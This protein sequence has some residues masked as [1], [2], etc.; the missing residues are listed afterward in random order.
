MSADE[1]SRIWVAALLAGDEQATKLLWD[2]YGEALQRVARRHVEP[3][4]RRRVEPEDIVQSACRSFFRHSA[5]GDY[6]LSDTESLWR[7]LCAITLTKVRQHARYHLRKKR[8]V[9]H[10]RDGYL[11]AEDAQRIDGKDPG[12][13]PAEAAEFADE[14]QQL[15]ASLNEEERQFLQLRLDGHSH[16]EIASKLMCSERTVGRIL[17][18]VRRR[19]ERQLQ[20][21]S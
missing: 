2:R 20:E 16:Q 21:S 9:Q 19:L 4:L 7:L 6:Q 8:S 1:S 3:A 5:R 13:T 18:R 11:D 15:I 17:K 14:L 10:E 12:P